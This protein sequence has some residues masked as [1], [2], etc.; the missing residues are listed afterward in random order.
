MRAPYNPSKGI[1]RLL[2]PSFP[3]K[4]EPENRFAG[5]GRNFRE[6]SGSGVWGFGF[7]VW[8]L[9]FRV[10]GPPTLAACWIGF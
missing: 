5:C 7:G 9:G 4:N 3:T 2:I 1:C 8:G 10:S 6:G